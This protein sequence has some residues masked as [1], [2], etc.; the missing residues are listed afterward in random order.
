MNLNS[1]EKIGID[2]KVV[3]YHNIS[4]LLWKKIVLVW[5]Q[6]NIVNLENIT[7]SRPKGLEF[8]NFFL[9]SLFLILITVLLFFLTLEQFFLTV[10]Q[11]N[12][13]NKI[14]LYFK[15]FLQVSNNLWNV[16][17]SLSASSRK[18]DVQVL[19]HTIQCQYIGL[20]RLNLILFSNISTADPWPKTS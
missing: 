12:Y 4:N 6:K 20:S 13:G 7:N 9:N 15:S 11:N 5:K 17:A 14:P 19:R 10:R 2:E 3:C 18:C 8:A 16:L 1:L